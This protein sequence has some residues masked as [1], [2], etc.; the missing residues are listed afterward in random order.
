MDALD[1]LL[2]R[3]SAPRLRAPIARR[4]VLRRALF[5][6]PVPDLRKRG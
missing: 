6:G 5:L 1:A 2:N 3:V 4:I